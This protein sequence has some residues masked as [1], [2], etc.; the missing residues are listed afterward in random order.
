MPGIHCGLL[1][2]MLDSSVH[3]KNGG[4]VGIVSRFSD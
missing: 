3:V 4:D 1:G 2:G